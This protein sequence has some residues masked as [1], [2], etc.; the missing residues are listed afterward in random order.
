MSNTTT[1]TEKTQSTDFWQ[2]KGWS[3]QVKSDQQNK[4][5]RQRRPFALV[6]SHHCC[7]LRVSSR[8]VP[9]I[10]YFLCCF[11]D[12]VEAW[13]L[14]NHGEKTAKIICTEQ[15]FSVGPCELSFQLDAG[16]KLP[17]SPSPEFEI[18]IEV[19][20]DRGDL[21][22]SLPQGVHLLSADAHDLKPTLEFAATHAAI[23]Q[24][25]SLWIVDLSAR[26]MRRSERIRRLSLFENEYTM[27]QSILAVTDIIPSG[28]ITEELDDFAAFAENP[29][30]ENSAT[31]S[32]VSHVHLLTE[33]KDLLFDSKACLD[34]DPELAERG[35]KR[36]TN[37]D[38]DPKNAATEVIAEPLLQ[39]FS[40]V[41]SMLSEFTDRESCER[42]HAI[43]EEPIE[44]GQVASSDKI[45][46]SNQDNRSFNQIQSA[47]SSST[48]HLLEQFA[49]IEGVVESQ[50]FGGDGMNGNL[51]NSNL[52]DSEQ[53]N[54]DG[55]Q[56][57][58]SM[59]SGM[60]Q[61]HWFTSFA[62][63]EGLSDAVPSELTQ[64]APAHNPNNRHSPLGD[65]TQL[66][67]T[68]NYV[69]AQKNLE[70][71]CEVISSDESR[72]TASSELPG[73]A[74]F[75][76]SEQGNPVGTDPKKQKMHQVTPTS[77]IPGPIVDA[78]AFAE[79]SEQAQGQAENQQAN[80]DNNSLDKALETTDLSQ[81]NEEI[82]NMESRGDY[83]D[84]SSFSFVPADQEPQQQFAGRHSET[85]N[86]AV[87]P[88]QPPPVVSGSELNIQRQPSD[89]TEV[90]NED[91]PTA[92]RKKV[93][94][95][96][97]YKIDPDELTTEISVRLANHVAPKRGFL[98]ALRRIFVVT[99]IIAVHVAVFYF[100]GQ[101]VY[102]LISAT[103]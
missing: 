27:G 75:G 73:Q 67:D 79:V 3:V 70:I 91:R 102:E 95:L 12:R 10:A 82:E 69:P 30:V 57:L 37:W 23:N 17:S 18:S 94:S 85:E 66:K 90:H 13:P 78:S 93:R 26:K 58:P 50:P 28:A 33:S 34:A 64:I 25:G 41:I 61:D 63:G 46:P 77:S 56:E 65:P 1:L 44:A 72:V 76:K 52:D 11:D 83:T 81:K 101:R 22:K 87:N 14:P 5:L 89:S 51:P 71:H 24:G 15:P 6:G 59:K 16:Q 40:G 36:P 9:A 84:M 32:S 31:D 21:H 20:N 97:D 4:T 42:T 7:H 86:K 80:Q 54:S 49:P 2:W 100:V 48:I 39:R 103:P 29:L 38:H 99:T 53:Q 45:V 55:S 8:S 35:K 98:S 19:L 74:M 47:K 96:S 43:S 60:P 62:V 68:D 92:F 88:V